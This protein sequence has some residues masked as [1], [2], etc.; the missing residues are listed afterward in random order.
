MQLSFPNGEH[1]DVNFEA[2]EV[3][4]GSRQDVM[5]SLPESGLAAHHVSIYADRRGTWLKVQENQS[6]VHLNGRPV[7]QLAY[8]RCGD[9]IC[10]EQL[11]MQLRESDANA[12][13]RK[14]PE[15]AP[16]NNNEAQKVSAARLLLRSLNGQH[17]GRTY[18]LVT[19][20]SM[21]SGIN[22]DIC[23][24]DKAIAEKHASVEWH[25]DRVIL[26]ANNPKAVS[27]VNG[28]AVTD[29]VLSPG[30]QITIE[31]ARFLLEA[32]GL[33]ARGRELAVAASSA[34]HTQT[35]QKVKSSIP[36]ASAEA[37]GQSDDGQPQET[38]SSGSSDSNA[39]WWL[40]AV[41]ALIAAGITALL[42]YAPRGGG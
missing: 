18:G 5:I 28:I 30:D 12:I 1:R 27:F 33:L 17:F 2:G 31:Q 36:S 41:A 37:S 35:I 38:E 10:I 8:L 20:V 21:G 39:L 4:I 40:I 22:A 32:P 14:I 13:I 6:G 26:R 9:L 19:P 29:A 23:I 16:T 24:E 15:G 3:K 34:A 42:V 25:G 11:R 7:K